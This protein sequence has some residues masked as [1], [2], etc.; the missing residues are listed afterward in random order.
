[1]FFFNTFFEHRTGFMFNRSLFCFVTMKIM[2][3]IIRLKRRDDVGSTKQ[4]NQPI[5]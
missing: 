1:M 5:T 3:V 4:R 2:A